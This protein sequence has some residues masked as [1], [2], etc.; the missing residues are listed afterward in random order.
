MSQDHHSY[1]YLSR[2]VTV[3]RYLYISGQ[4]TLFIQIP[5]HT[6]FINKVFYIYNKMLFY[7]LN[8]G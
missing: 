2:I 3:I 5:G 4:S 8:S 1:I 6:F 7:T